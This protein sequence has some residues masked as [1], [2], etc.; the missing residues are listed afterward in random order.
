MVLLVLSPVVVWLVK[1]AIPFINGMG[2]NGLV[3]ITLTPMA[4][5]VC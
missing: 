3:K 2:F 5:A 1:V 4:G